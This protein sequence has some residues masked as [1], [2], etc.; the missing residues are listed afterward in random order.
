MIFK[1]EMEDNF[2]SPYEICF[3]VGV[4]EFIM[5]IILLIIFSN[6]S[7]KPSENMTHFNE[8]S[9]DDFFAYID[10]L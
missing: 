9:I 2:S 8:N 4:F 10:K 3:I 5:F 6:V 1:L 7:M